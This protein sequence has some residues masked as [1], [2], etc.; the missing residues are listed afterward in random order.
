MVRTYTH[1][2]GCNLDFRFFLYCMTRQ[3]PAQNTSTQRHEDTYKEGIQTIWNLFYEWIKNGSGWVIKSVDTFEL[4]ICKYKPAR[5]SSYIPTPKS[6]SQKQAI[7]NPQNKDNECFKW[8]LL[9]ATHLVNVHP[10]RISNY[11]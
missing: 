3:H 8:S 6:I 4:A 10:E 9:A 2:G 1:A 11:I 5:G 7:V